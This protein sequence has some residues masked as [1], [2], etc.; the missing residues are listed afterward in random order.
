MSNGELRVPVVINCRKACLVQRGYADLVA[1]KAASASHVYI[2]RDMT[3]YVPGAVGSKFQ[4][5][6]K[7]KHG[8]IDERL[9]KF[10]KHIRSNPE[11]WNA[12]PE[13][14]EATE[15]GCWCAPAPCHGEVLVRLLREKLGAEAPPPPCASATSAPPPTPAASSASAAATSKILKEENF[16]SLD[17][18][19]K[20]VMKKKNR[21]Q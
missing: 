4:N 14:A 8:T 12:L 10:E 15:I 7:E 17:E 16:P 20:K 19:P 18:L 6:F 21:L 1:W 13:L 9:A 11:L 3:C 5:P 2:G